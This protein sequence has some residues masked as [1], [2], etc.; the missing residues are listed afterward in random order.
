MVPF[1]ARATVTPGA[2]CPLIA[3]F[4]SGSTRLGN[5]GI[6]DPAGAEGLPL[7]P[8]PAN[9]TASAIKVTNPGQISLIVREVFRPRL[10]YFTA[11]P[12]QVSRSRRR[13]CKWQLD[14]FDESRTVSASKALSFLTD[15]YPF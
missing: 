8:Q 5:D 6:F 2:P 9:A 15:A 14:R 3:A 13:E 11:S 7:P 4:T 12:I 10:R 1:F